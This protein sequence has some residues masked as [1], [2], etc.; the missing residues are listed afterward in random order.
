MYTVSGALEAQ[1]V[2][3][4]KTAEALDGTPLPECLS[5]L[6]DIIHY[7]CTVLYFS[8]LMD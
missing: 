6:S 2:A 7:K 1:E 8:L 3:E 5:L 4:E